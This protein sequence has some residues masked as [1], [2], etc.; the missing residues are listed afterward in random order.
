MNTNQNLKTLGSRA[1]FLIA[2]LYEQ[3]KTIF[4][5]NDVEKISGL[6]S[7]SARSLVRRLVHRGLATRLKPGLFILVPFELGHERDYIGN[8]YIVAG[9]IIG[10][11]DYY[12]SHSSAMDIHQMVT[13]PQLVVYATTTRAIRPRLV[14][15]TEFRFVRSKPE[16]IF[17]V[18]YHWITK[19]RKIRISD[20]ERT[21][22]DC[23]KQSEYCGGF[24]EIAKGF[25]MRREHIDLKKLV[26]YA[27]RLNIGAVYRR[28]GFLLEI[29]AL[30]APK[31]IDM[32][33][34]K[35][36]P[37]YAILDPMLPD[38]GKFVSRWRLRLNVSTEEIEAVVTT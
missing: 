19:S 3:Q 16:N 5:N 37:S 13:Q 1:A 35:L 8:P 26:G 9:E 18:T 32:L 20:L 11:P 4:S 25:W 30:E 7:K 33:Q 6:S 36:T 12:I 27:L 15:G 34:R 24:S 17:G 14:L 21:V 2:E 38:E 23:L 10:K 28:L 22:I 31:E 29:F